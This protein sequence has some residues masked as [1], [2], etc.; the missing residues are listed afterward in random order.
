MK[1]YFFL[2][3]LIA[4]FISCEK[5][6]TTIQPLLNTKWFLSSIQNTKTNAIT[7]YPNNLNPV[8]YIIFADSIKALMVGGVCNGCRGSYKISDNSI[9]TNGLSCTLIYCSKWE[10][11]LFYNLDSMFQY[12]INNN[13]LTIYSKGTYNLNFVA[14]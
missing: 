11:Y 6:D 10:D 7:S 1:K 2:I 5:K 3:L 4:A 13:L 12:K 14:K 9:S 8:E